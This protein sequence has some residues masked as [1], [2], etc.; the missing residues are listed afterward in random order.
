MPA[1]LV[2]LVL[3][4]KRRT[5]LA[6]FCCSSSELCHCTMLSYRTLTHF[7]IAFL[8][9]SRLSHLLLAECTILTRAP[10]GAGIQELT[11]DAQDH[12]QVQDCV[13]AETG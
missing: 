11:E 1:V 4:H 13:D 5:G 6:C 7:S 10:V 12:V 9:V 2:E 8:V 3:T